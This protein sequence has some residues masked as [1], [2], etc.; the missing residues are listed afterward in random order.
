MTELFITENK[1]LYGKAEM[2]LK[3]HAAAPV[4]I[5][6]SPNGKPYLAGNHLY[7]SLSHSGNAAVIAISE[8]PCGVDLELI[9][10]KKHD[11]VLK[12]FSDEERGEIENERDFLK[13]WT[14]RESYIKM[15]GLTLAAKLKDLKYVGGILYDCG[16]KT[17]CCIYSYDGADYVISLCI[18]SEDETPPVIKN[19]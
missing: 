18:Q 14:V 5:L 13:H 6:H 17:H 16:Q 10:W 1:D 11:A 12:K 15:H 9:R 3:Q 4:K 7:F 2:L 8:G 19:I